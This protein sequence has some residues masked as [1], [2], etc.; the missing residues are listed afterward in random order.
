MAEKNL[1][2][3]RGKPWMLLILA[4]GFGSLVIYAPGA[5]AKPKPSSVGCFTLAGAWDC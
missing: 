4:L 3:E 1:Q 2:G 5:G